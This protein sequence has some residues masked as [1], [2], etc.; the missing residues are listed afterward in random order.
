MAD[1]L[2]ALTQRRARRAFDARQAPADVQEALWRAVQAA[3][4]HGNAQPVRILV[5]ESADARERLVGALGQGNRSWAP[6]AP[7][8]FALA[9]I[10]SHDATFEG[11]DGQLRELWAFHAGIAAGNLMA[12]ATSLGLIAH[13]MASFD[14][15]AAR[16]PFAAPA[17]V[18]V[19]AI[20]A[21]GYPGEVTSLPDDLQR[22]E[23]SAQDRL[24]LDRIVGVDRW[25][26]AMSVSA[27]DVRR[28]GR[29]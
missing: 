3:P 1:V 14:E 26:D 11:D 19:L 20:F 18:R 23:T 25:N 8:L 17:E 4:S 6:A 21:A 5:A 28:Q 15:S 12:Q 9:A 22:R 27:R 10:P 29:A 13:P 16:K 24:A 2:E 7:L